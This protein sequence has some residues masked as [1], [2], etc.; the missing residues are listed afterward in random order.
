MRRSGRGRDRMTRRTGNGDGDGDGAAL[1]VAYLIAAR[2]TVRL[3]N[4]GQGAS[5][6]ESIYAVKKNTIY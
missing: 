4:V 3:R 6:L 1:S 5:S 2:E